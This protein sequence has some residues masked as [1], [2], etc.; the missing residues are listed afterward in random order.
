[1]YIFPK[2]NGI[3][4]YANVFFPPLYKM[5]LS[6]WVTCITDTTW[7]TPAHRRRPLHLAFYNLIGSKVWWYDIVR[8]RP[9]R[10]DSMSGVQS[11]FT[12]KTARRHSKVNSCYWVTEFE[13]SFLS[14]SNDELSTEASKQS[15]L[16]TAADTSGWTHSYE[17]EQQTREADTHVCIALACRAGG[18]LVTWL[19]LQLLHNN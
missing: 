13:T 18:K 10:L 19:L 11:P 3:T 15:L 9:V 6:E 5:T 8:G 14:H 1:M 7:I 12:Q 17:S 2:E 16:V 4:W